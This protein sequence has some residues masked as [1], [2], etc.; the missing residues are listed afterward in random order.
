MTTNIIQGGVVKSKKYKY[1]N[2]VMLRE[3]TCSEP[4]TFYT[5]D[6]VF[7][8]DNKVI[9]EMSKKIDSWLHGY[10]FPCIAPIVNSMCINL[11]MPRSIKKMNSML[12]VSGRGSGKSE[13]LYEILAKSNPDHFMILNEKT[14][15][16]ELIQEKSA[17]FHNKIMVRDDIIPLFL[18]MSTK[19]REQLINFWVSLLEGRYARKGSKLENVKTMVLFGI[20]SEMYLA[21][22]KTMLTTTFSDRAPSYFYDFTKEQKRDILEKRSNECYSKKII[23]ER[24]VI[25]LPLPEVI[26]DNKKVKIDFPKNDFIEEAIID[27]AMELDKYAIQSFVRSQ[28]YIKVFMMC[29]AMLNERPKVTLSDLELYAIIHPYFL[30]SGKAM[31]IDLAI[32]NVMK[33]NPGMEDIL[34]IKKLGISKGTFYKYKK[35]L[36]EKGLY[37]KLEV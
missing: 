24:P 26:E 23:R 34:L 7:K 13:L 17:F 30:Q 4:Y 35:K 37:K 21:H 20:A 27:F 8:K 15:E 11:A 2:I 1:Q 3:V 19:Q 22:A 6:K 14:F 33:E 16:S 25:K 29:N 28:D 32:L 5:Q 12:I 36:I 9:I 18:G 31:S 10:M